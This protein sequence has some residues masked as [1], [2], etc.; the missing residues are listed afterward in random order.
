M[1]KHG[2]YEHQKARAWLTSPI[3]IGYLSRDTEGELRTNRYNSGLRR[4]QYVQMDADGNIV[5]GV[6]PVM[7]MDR[8]LELQHAIQ[9]RMDM[10]A[11]RT[12][13]LLQGVLTCER[14][15]YGMTR[16]KS[17]SG[18][19]N[20]I[21][22]NTKRGTCG[23]VNI[24]MARIDEYI[25]S[26]MLKRYD[27]AQIENS[28][29]AYEEEIERLKAAMPTG[30][31]EELAELSAKLNL[32]TDMLLDETSPAGR[33]NLKKK[34]DDITKK[35]DELQTF[36]AQMPSAPSMSVLLDGA[37]IDGYSLADLWT[38][39][40]IEKRNAFIRS[41]VESIQIKTVKR[42]Q[43]EG[44]GRFLFD[45]SRVVIWWRGTSK[46]LAWDQQHASHLEVS[47]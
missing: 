40:P 43:S 16:A 46:P 32:I 4:L 2:D 19:T 36:Q 8:W 1:N 28:R 30:H 39:L 38:N 47:A 35:I 12:P 10:R 27:P 26:E 42:N 31:T 15:G 20:Y 14:C 9:S 34:R 44:N 29:L 3:L 41:A 22:L 45:P 21:C 25:E 33:E 7:S 5:R 6:D 11:P 13:F 23:G 37:D 24:S 18:Y 17:V